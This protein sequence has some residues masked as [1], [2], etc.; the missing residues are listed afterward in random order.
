MTRFL[1]RR[2]LNYVVLL[3][4]ASFLTFCLTSAD[5]LAAGKPDA[6]QPATATE[7]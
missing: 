3:A 5:V 4:L 7:A 2:V 6:A 1:A